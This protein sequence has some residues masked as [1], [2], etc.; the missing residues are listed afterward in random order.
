MSLSVIAVIVVKIFRLPLL[1]SLLISV[2]SQV[3]PADA[4]SDFLDA[5]PPCNFTAA[6]PDANII[7]GAVVYNIETGSGCA[8]NL[9]EFFPVASVPKLFVAG[10]LFDWIL[11]SDV[12][13]FDTE[14][15]F[16]ERY[17][18]GGRG[19]CLNGA[20]LN[21]PVTLGALG[22]FMIYCS[23]NA[24]TWML[25]DAM[26]WERVDSYINAMGISDVGQVIPL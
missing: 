13:G 2:L 21:A 1:L 5:L 25:M 15:T 24:A 3:M 4:Q 14:L 19:D 26:G 22:D 9:D 20:A 7:I 8:E 18:M 6:A 16:S 12:I 10:A 17:W 23:D 11:E